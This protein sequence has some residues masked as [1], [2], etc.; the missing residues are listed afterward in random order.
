MTACILKFTA[1]PRHEGADAA[2]R[3]ALAEIVIFPGIRIE[4]LEPAE[5]AAAEAEAAEAVVIKEAL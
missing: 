1:R 3:Q 4:R 2:S 5:T